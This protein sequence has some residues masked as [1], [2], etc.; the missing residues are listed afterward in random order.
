MGQLQIG[1]RV[2]HRLTELSNFIKMSPLIILALASCAMAA[3]QLPAG[4]SIQ[5][6]V[7]Y[8][9]CDQKFG[10]LDIPD[11]PGAAEIIRGQELLIQSRKTVSALPGIEAH[12]AAEAQVLEASRAG[13]PA[14]AAAIQA[15]LLQ[16]RAPEGLTAGKYAH[17]KAEQAV[18]A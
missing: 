11:V 14:H 7:N 3:P 13:F 16:G 4:L 9:Y 12:Q 8:P 18:I 10:F 1:S 15:V 5:D 2:L 6:C 17:Y